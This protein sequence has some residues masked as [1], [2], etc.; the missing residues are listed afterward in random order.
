ML[1]NLSCVSVTHYIWSIHL[2]QVIVITYEYIV[3]C[4]CNIYMYIL[5]NNKFLI[6]ERYIYNNNCYR[7][8]ILMED[9]IKQSK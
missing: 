3:I 5:I 6:I 8:L 2:Y 4:K 7:K 1:F 9:N